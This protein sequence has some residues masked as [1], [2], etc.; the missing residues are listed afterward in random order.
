VDRMTTRPCSEWQGIMAMDAIGR[1]DP[2]ASTQLADHLRSCEQCRSDAADVRSAADALV[3]LDSGQVADLTTGPGPVP[4]LTTDGAGSRRDRVGAMLAE[5]R[6]P[7]VEFPG[8]GALAGTDSDV[9]TGAVGTGVV[10]DAG[11][12]TDAVVGAAAKHRR[13]MVGA[14]AAL[15]AVAAAVMAVLTLGGAPVPPSRSVALTGPS[16]V[17]ASVSLTTQ[18]WGTHATLRESGQAAG[19]V[20]T[21]WMKSSSGRS[22]AAGSYRTTGHGGGVVVQLSCAV[23][24]DQVASVW[25]SNQSGHSVLEGYLS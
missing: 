4:D 21:V 6:G 16:G 25:V 24:A 19:Q 10:A 12:R 5:D 8:A 22:W 20:L 18:T 2:D 11:V 9:G 1:A 7:V 17:V 14:G 23:Q 13:W 15:V 3:L